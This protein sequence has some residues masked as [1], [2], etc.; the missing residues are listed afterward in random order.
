[1]QD[2]INVGIVFGGRSGEHEVSL[3]SAYNVIESIDQNKYIV[4]MIGITKAGQWRIYKGDPLNLKNNT[5]QDDLSNV[6]TD[7]SLFN[8]DEM[9]TI[10][11]FFPV[12]HGTFGED[13]TI[14][15]LFEM[16][17][18]PYVGCGVLASS[19]AMDKDIAKIIFKSE[20]IPVAGGI[21]LYKS[22][23]LQDIHNAIDKIETLYRY[24]VF[25]KPANMGSSVGISKAH[26]QKELQVA[27]KE[28]VKYDTK[29]LVEEFIQGKE[30]E[31][32][33]L[34]NE[35][36]ETSCTG[37]VVPCHEFYDYEA[38]YLTGDDSEIIIPAPIEQTLSET[39]KTYAKKAFKAINGSGLARVDFFVQD[40]TDKIYLNEI[41]TMPGFTNISM[42][43]KLWEASGIRYVDLIDK[44]I[45]LGFERYDTRQKLIYEIEL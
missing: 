18:K 17:N 34:G 29:I 5:W 41:N 14:Q 36:P 2:K 12:L 26:N 28:A 33:V 16:L 32:A 45:E 1:M 43:S 42:Y 11:I 30:I 10:D 13:G 15:G 38:K 37:H 19:V 25:I 24:P 6:K 22:E 39:I 23:I 31:V 9:K 27:L 3:N 40:E 35:N 21:L 44:L 7:F 4:T 8:D 20:D